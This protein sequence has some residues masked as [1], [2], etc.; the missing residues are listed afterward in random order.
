[1]TDIAARAIIAS[2]LLLAGCAEPDRPLSWMEVPNEPRVESYLFQQCLR[3]AKGPTKTH[4]NDWDEAINACAA[5]A[6]SQSRYCP[7]GAKCSP[8]ISSRADVLAILPPEP[9][10]VQP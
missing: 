9:P 10:Q 4:Y 1:M 7:A 2:A 8:S 5:A 6:E 3:S